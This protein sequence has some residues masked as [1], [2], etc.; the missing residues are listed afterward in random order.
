VRGRIVACPRGSN[1]F[2]YDPHFEIDDGDLIEFNGR[3]MAELGLSEKNRI[4]HR[5]RAYRALIDEVRR[6][7]GAHPTLD[8]LLRE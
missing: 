3:T 6:A 1:G 7:A 8:I 4:S 5:S 2:G